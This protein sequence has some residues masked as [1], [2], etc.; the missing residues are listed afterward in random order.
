MD[1]TTMIDTLNRAS[2]PSPRKRKP[3]KGRRA[4]AWVLIGFGLKLAI[5]AAFVI[6]F[7]GEDAALAQRAVPPSHHL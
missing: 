2:P 3:R 5:T 4:V 1:Y 6:A 7:A